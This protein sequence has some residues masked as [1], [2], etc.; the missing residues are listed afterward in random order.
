MDT[1]KFL[2]AITVALLVG[3]LA[4]SW[5]NFRQDV[6]GTPP[7]ELAEVQRQIAEI[8]QQRKQLQVERDQLMQVQPPAPETAAPETAAIPEVA[9]PEM[10]ETGA[11]FGDDLPV[12]EGGTPDA[13]AVQGTEERAKAI[14]AAA[15]VAKLT[16]WVEDPQLGSFATLQVTDAAAVKAGTV[17]CVRRGSGILGKLEVSEVTP[18]GALANAVSVFGEV[19]PKAGDELIVEPAVP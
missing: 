12:A 3:A 16:E 9:V 18:E 8:E 1:I 5:K 13:P 17:L 19:K 6:R 15:V 2:L 7:K 10:P 4:M 11:V 14:A